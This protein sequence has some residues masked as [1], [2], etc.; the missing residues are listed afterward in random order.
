MSESAGRL[1]TAR[2]FKDNRRV[3]SELARQEAQAAVRTPTM[4][5]AVTHHHHNV[6]VPPAPAG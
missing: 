2:Y 1:W 3:E 6:A 4:A 5:D